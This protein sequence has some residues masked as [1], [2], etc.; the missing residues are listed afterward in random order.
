[1]EAPCLARDEPS[2]SDHVI[3][4]A[5]KERADNERIVELAP[6]LS[7]EDLRPCARNRTHRRVTQRA[8]PK[9]KAARRPLR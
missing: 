4:W 9:T 6:T 1:M 2:D 7:C 8:S 3:T 5:A